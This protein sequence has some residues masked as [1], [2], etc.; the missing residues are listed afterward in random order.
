[1]FRSRRGVDTSHLRLFSLTNS[2]KLRGLLPEVLRQE[3]Q[4]TGEEAP[5]GGPLQALRQSQGRR[6]RH[7]AEQVVL[8]L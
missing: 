6:G 5:S 8:H 4:V 7:P 2:L 3:R 1:M